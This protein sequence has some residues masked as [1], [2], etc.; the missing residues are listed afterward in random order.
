MSRISVVWGSARLLGE[1]IV[2]PSSRCSVLIVLLCLGPLHPAGAYSVL[3]HEQLIDL[4]WRSAIAP[5]L[6]SRFPNLTPEE[7]RRAHSFAYGGCVIQDAGYYPFGNGFFSDLTHYVRSGDFVRSLFRNARNADELAFAIGALSHYVGDSIG[8]S[9]AVNRAVALEFPKL[10]ARFGPS[11][12]YAESKDAHGRVEFAFDINQIVKERLPPSAYLH[13]IGFRVPRAQLAAAFA[14][15]YGLPV[16][17]ILG[18]YREALPSYRFGA[19]S[20]IP[21]FAYAEAFLHRHD[22]PAEEPGPELE[23]YQENMNRL[24]PESDWHRYRKKPGLRT[25][26]LAGLIAVLPKIGPISILAIKGPTLETEKMYLQSVNRSVATLSGLLDDLSKPEL[27]ASAAQSEEPQFPATS[28]RTGLR[29]VPAAV[30]L[31]NRDLDTGMR[32]RPGGY[33]LTDKTYAKLLNRL[34]ETPAAPIPAGL[35]EDILQ[36]YADPDAPIVTRKN[37]KKWAAVQRELR[38]LMSAP[39]IPHRD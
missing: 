4:S 15:T 16:Q 32:V 29:K 33:P 18:L 38:I 24:H 8:H 17:G 1:R 34:A 37:R 28:D 25:H 22:F 31:P 14:E 30:L 11:V 21:A 35:K 19:R 2:R 10:A 23:E 39:T 3:T 7:L 12:S 9:V 6:L 20:F 13:Y 5:L 36:Y 26:L 27:P